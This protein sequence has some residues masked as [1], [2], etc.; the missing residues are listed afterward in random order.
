MKQ[1]TCGVCGGTDF[2]IK[3]DVFICKSCGSKYFYEEIRKSLSKDGSEADVKEFIDKYY[4][5]YA[6]YAIAFKNWRDAIKY[7]TIIQEFYPNNVESQFYIAYAKARRTFKDEVFLR[8][9]KAFYN[10]NR[11]LEK[12]GDYY[13]LGERIRMNSLK[14]LTDDLSFMTYIDY[15]YNC[16]EELDEN[17][18]PII[19]SDKR[20]TKILFSN[21]IIQHENNIKQTIQKYNKSTEKE[22]YEFSKPYSDVAR[23]LFL[24]LIKNKYTRI[25]NIYSQHDEWDTPEEIALDKEN[26]EKTKKEIDEI[27][28]ILRSFDSKFDLSI[29]DVE[30]FLKLNKMRKEMLANKKDSSNSKTIKNSSNKQ[31]NQVV[32]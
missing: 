1:L 9:E 8:R 12:I 5:R 7:Y 18:K 19:R 30:N 25:E 32:I 29:E 21:V 6:S 27:Y 23:L 24:E 17:N 10:F 22:M 3:N 31:K 11:A 16:W 20:K 28:K 15:I 26:I 4:L 14:S 2:S 13:P